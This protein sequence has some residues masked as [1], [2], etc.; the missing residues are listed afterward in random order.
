L[1]LAKL[2]SANLTNALADQ[3]KVAG[4]DLSDAILDRTQMG[5]LCQRAGGVNSQTGIS[6]GESLGCRQE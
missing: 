5:E 3:V 6:T 2:H 1:T 4:A